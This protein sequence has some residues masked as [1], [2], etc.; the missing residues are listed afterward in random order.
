MLKFIVAAPLLAVGVALLFVTFVLGHNGGVL[1]GIPAVVFLS[2]GA[3]A[4]TAKS[5]AARFASTI[6]VAGAIVCL[7]YIYSLFN[8]W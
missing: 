6:L 4:A 1:A 2:L 7:A 8:R 5:L 3:F